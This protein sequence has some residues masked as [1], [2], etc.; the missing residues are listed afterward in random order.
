MDYQL[1]CLTGGCT[2]GGV[3][4]TVNLFPSGLVGSNPTHPIKLKYLWRG[5]VMVTSQAHNLKTSNV[6][7]GSNPTPAII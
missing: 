3:R 4:Q 2:D 6:R 1:K 5:S 7:V